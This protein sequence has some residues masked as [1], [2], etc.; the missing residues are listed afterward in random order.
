M[1]LKMP[2]PFTVPADGRDV[3][4]CFVVPI[5]VDADKTVVAVDFHP[6]NRKVVHHAIFYL[7]AAGMARL[8]AGDAGHYSTFGGP[9]ILPTGGLGSWAPGATPRRLPEGVGK[10]IRKGSDLV[11]QI[12]YHP[13][14]KEETDQSSVGVYFAAKPADKLIAGIGLINRRI[15]IA[16]GTKDYKLTAD[17][18]PLPADVDALSIG[19]HMHNLGREMRVEAR[20]PDGTVKPMIH[21]TD[22]DWNWQGA[23]YFKTPMRLPKG[24]VLHMEARYDNSTDNPRNPSNPPQ[25][26]RWGEQTTDEMCLCGVQV[27]ADSKAELLKIVTMRNNQLGLILGGGV[28]PDVLDGGPKGDIPIPERFKAFLEPYDKNK[29]GK[30]SPEEIDAMPDRIKAMVKAYLR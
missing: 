10:F 20:L 19:P 7:D 24:T 26:V 13:N 23:Y 12:H 17:S 18:E 28:T 14:G 6:G 3:Q 25:R 1:V 11:L 21:V 27:V 4:E 5:P 9:G 22:W 15:D 29:D 16:P 2:K 8:K 30:L